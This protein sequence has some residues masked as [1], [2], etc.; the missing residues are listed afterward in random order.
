[1]GSGAWRAVP[2]G[3]VTGR[4]RVITGQP[5]GAHQNLPG[6][7]RG[8]RPWLSTAK[9]CTGECSID[10]A[11]WAAASRYQPGSGS[12]SCGPQAPGTR[13][14]AARRLLESAVGI[15]DT[16]PALAKALRASH[17]AANSFRST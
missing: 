13:L 12:A 2:A 9:S 4:R 7:F 1:M 17:A 6:Y 3:I 10:R 14:A 15:R 8:G 5:S 11:R 16:S